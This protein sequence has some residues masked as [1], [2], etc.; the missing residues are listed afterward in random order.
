MEVGCGL[1]QDTA[2]TREGMTNGL[3]GD[4][5]FKIALASTGVA[6]AKERAAYAHPSAKGDL[7][8]ATGAVEAAS[9]QTSR[10]KR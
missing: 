9:C 7:N 8:R 4:L 5:L 1:L 10:G 6:S 3:C 2:D